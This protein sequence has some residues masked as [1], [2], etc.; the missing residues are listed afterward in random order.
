MTAATRAPPGQ[1]PEAVE[2]EVEEELTMKE[3][4]S[5]TRT[6]VKEK[7]DEQIPKRNKVKEEGREA[8]LVAREEVGRGT[9]TLTKREDD[10]AAPIK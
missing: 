5:G 7:D 3:K 8:R 2:E 9:R 1:P 10:N 6:S 4:S